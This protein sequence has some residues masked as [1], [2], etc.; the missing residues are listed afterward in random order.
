[1]TPLASLP[2][3]K[4]IK[5]K[6]LMNGEQYLPLFELEHVEALPEMKLYRTE[7]VE[8]FE[9]GS[10]FENKKLIA[11]SLRDPEKMSG[12]YTPW[13]M[14]RR[15]WSYKKVPLAQGTTYFSLLDHWGHEYYHWMAETLPRLELALRHLKDVT[16][17]LSERHLKHE[18]VRESLKYFP[19]K[20]AVLPVKSYAQV[21]ALHFT[22]FPGPS[23]YHRKDLLHA[24]RR[25]FAPTI[26]Q[27]KRRIYLSRAKARFRTITNEQEVS[28]FLKNYG[29]ETIY[30]EDYRWP[31][32]IAL[33]AE[34]S[35][36]VTIHGAGLSNIL[37][38]PEGS[39]VMEIRKSDYGKNNAGE[40][41][42]STLCNTYYHMAG[43]LGLTYS[44][45]LSSS[46]TPDGNY[47]YSDLTVDLRA[48]KEFITPIL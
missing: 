23:D 44:A 25:R 26:Q 14:F 21:P 40:P 10:I 9:D 39:H 6:P 8:L 19:V 31:D 48:L 20:T 24:L 7:N 34:A 35:H 3:E 47:G 46:P 41:N 29:F 42:T 18:F 45:L 16:V 38:M 30:A 15:R 36:L 17:I 13:R 27:P 32:Q 37:F 5:T 28:Q 12:M 2:A 43:E 33:F 1:M 11:P 22:D 4:F